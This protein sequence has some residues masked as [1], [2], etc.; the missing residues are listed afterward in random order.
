MNEEELGQKLMQSLMSLRFL[1]RR[2][3]IAGLKRNE[4][5]LLMMIYH[6]GNGEG[7]KVSEISAHMQVTSSSVTQMVTALEAQGQVQ[8]RMDPADRRSVRVTLTEQGNQAVE[9]AKK[10]LQESFAYV[11]RQMGPEKLTTLTEL[12]SEIGAIAARRAAEAGKDAEPEDPATQRHD[13][14]AHE[15][16]Q[17]MLWR[18]APAQPTDDR[19]DNDN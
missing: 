1:F 14:H 3:P 10:S 12:I 5:G 17:R 9:A 4:F 2:E 11:L 19:P 18:D 16:M 6:H 13:H 7:M 15:H 8:R